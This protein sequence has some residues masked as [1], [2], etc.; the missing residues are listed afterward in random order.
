MVRVLTV[1][2]LKTKYLVYTHF[3][4][5]LCKCCYCLTVQLEITNELFVDFSVMETV[6]WLLNMQKK[7]EGVL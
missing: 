5:M 4:L 2:A 7:K 6:R 3:L 1:S